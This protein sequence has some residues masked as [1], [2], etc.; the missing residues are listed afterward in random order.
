MAQKIPNQAAREASAF[1][2]LAALD[3]P[4]QSIW[5]MFAAA[6]IARDVQLAEAILDTYEE[7]IIR[8]QKETR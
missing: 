8:K 7:R 3:T 6:V 4:E 5:V 2:R 1:D